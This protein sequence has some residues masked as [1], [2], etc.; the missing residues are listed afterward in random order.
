MSN[1][2][3]LYCDFWRKGL[4]SLS[5]IEEL[6][7]YCDKNNITD[8]FVQYKK[9]KSTAY[10]L[11]QMKDN[12]FDYFDEIN[13]IKGDIRTHLWVS[14]LVLYRKKHITEVAFDKVK[15]ELV[16]DN[17]NGETLVY[18]DPILK[19]NRDLIVDYINTLGVKTDGIH[20][21]RLWYPVGRNMGLGTKEEKTQSLTDIVVRVRE[22]NPH[23]H[24][25]ITAHLYD[26]YSEKDGKYN[27]GFNDWQNWLKQKYVDQ[28]YILLLRDNV[29]N[30][31]WN[32]AKD[33]TNAVAVN[34]NNVYRDDF[35]VILFSYGTIK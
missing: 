15:M 25:S 33:M 30:N 2:K 13:K 9:D 5:E 4:R 6:K 20:I 23:K 16:N 10:R 22:S 29:E 34:I 21:D 1:V 26:L 19:E 7:S 17:D 8:L 35:D 27:F 14:P 32:I 18:L 31:I 28:V 12:H 3:G 24:I 11:R